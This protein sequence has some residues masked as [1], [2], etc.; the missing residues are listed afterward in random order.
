MCLVCV[1]NWNKFTL[2][3]SCT[4]EGNFWFA[5]LLKVQPFEILTFLPVCPRLDGGLWAVAVNPFTVHSC[6][7]GNVGFPGLG[8]CP[9]EQTG[10]E[11][12]LP[13]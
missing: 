4:E 7:K 10:L 13:L 8:L 2:L 11:A 9:T 5:F 6:Q 3:S 1:M 12:G